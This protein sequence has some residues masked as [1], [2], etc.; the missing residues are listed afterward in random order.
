MSNYPLIWSPA[1]VSRPPVPL[2]ISK[3]KLFTPLVLLFM[4][5]LHASRL[6]RATGCIFNRLYV[7]LASRTETKFLRIS[8]S[9]INCN[10]TT[11]YFQYLLSLD[12]DPFHP[13]NP[14]HR[15]KFLMNV[16]SDCL[17]LLSLWH[18]YPLLTRAH[19]HTSCTYDTA[20]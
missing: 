11:I 15:L 3:L 8:L 9:I 4:L 6:T 19:A 14:K 20:Q 1:E 17:S 7:E 13:E 10:K 18:A 12:R 2:F 5:Y 16:S